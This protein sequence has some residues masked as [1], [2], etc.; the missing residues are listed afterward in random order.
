M[1]R[2]FSVENDIS[3]CKERRISLSL[4]DRVWSGCV[5]EVG[6]RRKEAREREKEE[7]VKI[8]RRRVSEIGEGDLDSRE[9]ERWGGG[10][11]LA[12]PWIRH[13]SIRGEERSDDTPPW[14]NRRIGEGAPSSLLPPPPHSSPPRTALSPTLFSSALTFTSIL[15]PTSLVIACLAVTLPA[16]CL[17]PTSSLSS[18]FSLARFSFSITIS[19][20]FFLPF[21]FPR[22]K[23][24]GGSLE[25]IFERENGKLLR[26]FFFFPLFKSFVFRLLF[27]LIRSKLLGFFIR[28]IG[29]VKGRLGN[30]DVWMS[31]DLLLRGGF[32]REKGER[33]EGR[34]YFY[35]W[36]IYWLCNAW[37]KRGSLRKIFS[38]EIRIF[39]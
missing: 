39:L 33:R 25:R 31:I 23:G 6:I 13:G 38:F 1:I 24:R 2:N 27:L 8:S 36:S 28:F 17:R 16:P 11:S 29:K 18:L 15:R 5:P 34:Y 4:S 12:R 32:L 30:L 7:I 14:A 10:E 19:F 3:H 21:P 9:E 37:L 26:A 22:R 20:S 35:N